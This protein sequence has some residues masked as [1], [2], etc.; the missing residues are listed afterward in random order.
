MDSRR[1]RQRDQYIGVIPFL[2]SHTC[3]GVDGVRAN[4]CAQPPLV[5][6]N[7]KMRVNV[8]APCSLA[9]EPAQPPLKTKLPKSSPTPWRGP[10]LA[11]LA[12]GAAR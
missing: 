6:T 1:R 11:S 7:A 12:S 5:Q 10:V 2:V 9:P 4:R 3:A 8:F